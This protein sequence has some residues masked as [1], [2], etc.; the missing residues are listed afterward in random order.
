MAVA[1]ATLAGAIITSQIHWPSDAITLNAK[2]LSLVSVGGSATGSI[3]ALAK[4]LLL[5]SASGKVDL[6]LP[7]P[8]ADCD[9][10]QQRANATCGAD[11]AQVDQPIS[12]SWTAERQVE[13]REATGSSIAWMTLPQKDG[14]GISVSVTGSKAIPLCIGQAVDSAPLT[15]RIGSSDVTFPAISPPIATCSGLKVS[16]RSSS[17]S[18]T[19]GFFLHGLIDLRSDFQGSQL[20]LSAEG[21]RLTAHSTAT[22]SS[23]DGGSMKVVSDRP[24]LFT[25]TGAPPDAVAKDQVVPG[26]TTVTEADVE[27]LPSLYNHFT[28]IS[29]LLTL[30]G[31]L[32]A[33]LVW[34][35]GYD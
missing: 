6:V 32:G 11:G 12:G 35:L 31:A 16:L 21:I 2:G 23:Y 7:V 18:Q 9:L 33:L 10:L 20:Q 28:W 24:F 13:V 4:S 26:A 29:Y 17:T 34:R 5:N 25:A 14:G 1:A 15:L 3:N 30:V 19:S 8:A 22:D 27:R